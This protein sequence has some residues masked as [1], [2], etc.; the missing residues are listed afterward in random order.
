MPYCQHYNRNTFEIPTVDGSRSEVQ[1]RAVLSLLIVAL[2][3][4][5]YLLTL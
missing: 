5:A 3:T 4:R 1:L 2:R